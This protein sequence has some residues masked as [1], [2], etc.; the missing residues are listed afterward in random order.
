MSR[1]LHILTLILL[2]ACLTSCHKHELKPDKPEV[3]KSR[4]TVVVYMVAENSL[5]S[6]AAKD[7][8]EIISAKD[9]I[10]LDCNLVVYVDDTQMP[11]I[12]TYTAATGRSEWRTYTEQNSCDGEV[13]HKVL[14]DIT[15]YFPARSYG[16]IMWSHGSGWLPAPKAKAPR[17][18][19][20][21]DNMINSGHSDSGAE[22]EIPVMR[23]KL[24]ELG[25]H[26]DYIFF[27]ACFMQCAEVDY[28]LRDV[29]DYVVASPA[30]I[31]GEGAPYH[32]I[33]P[34]LFLDQGAAQEITRI[35]HQ[36]NT[37]ITYGG[38]THGGLIISV[39]Q[40]NQMEALATRIR[41]Y[42]Q[43]LYAGRREHDLTQ[44]QTYCRYYPY[45]AGSK[46]EYYDLGSAM[47]LLLQ[48]PSD[49]EDLMR[50]VALS[51]PLQL[52]TPYWVSIFFP[53]SQGTVTDP[54]HLACASIFLP[55]S[56]Y[57]TQGYNQRL[58]DYQWYKAAGWDATGW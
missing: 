22:L 42:I 17:K 5:D 28:E 31:P 21:I 15:D 19:I 44:A 58:R 36:T 12:Y 1:F 45:D 9:Q 46:T 29:C 35:Y 18:T 10:P 51:Y 32:L 8:R 3:P 13:F 6:Y 37:N 25:L 26:W 48:S 33:M 20:G 41:P 27:D 50:Q 40:S 23:A 53:G 2:T 14:K 43:R 7:L 52:Q 55:H 16:L 4:K 49:Y 57:D 39:A 38:G 11:A 30:E 34:A 24:Q 56:K 54:T 47:N